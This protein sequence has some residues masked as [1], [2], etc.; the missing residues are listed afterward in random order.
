MVQRAG[1]PQAGDRGPDDGQPDEDPG[2]EIGPDNVAQR[3]HDALAR[4]AARASVSLL[5]RMIS[6]AT[7]I[8]A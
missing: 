2:L 3:Q 4:T 8:D 1:P 6:G 7:P 5:S